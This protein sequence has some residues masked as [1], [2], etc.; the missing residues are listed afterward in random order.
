MPEF[1]IQHLTRYIYDSPVRDSANQIILYPIKDEY[2]DVLKQEIT[3]TGNPIVD[4]HIDYYGNEVGSFTYSE[5]HSVLIINSKILVSTKHRALPVNDIFPAQQ[6]EDLK[7]LKYMVPYIDFLRQEYFEGLSE[8][9]QIVESERLKDDTPYQVALRFCQYVYENFEYIKGVTTVETTL[10][11]IWKI[12]AGVCQD[13]AH[14]LT[15]ML[16]L[17]KIPARYVSGYI[18]TYKNG[19]RGEGATHAWAEAYI[20]DY[21][22]LG[23]DPTN[24]CIAND[25]HVRLAVG[26]NFS[27]CS[28]VKGVY[29][30]ASGHRLEVSVSVDDDENTLATIT[31]ETPVNEPAVAIANQANTAIKNSYQRYMEMMQQQQQQ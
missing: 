8:L 5:P 13:F 20:P 24:N 28:P 7:P 2:Q 23:L 12:R 19:M 15:E 30:G 11:E 25:T 16:R 9:Q 31:E 1:E 6:W 26:R 4:S 29:K 17:V 10:D 14:I 27:D 3:I 18:C 22:W 21:G